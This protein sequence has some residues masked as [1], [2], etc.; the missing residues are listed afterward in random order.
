MRLK[1]HKK[2]KPL[3]S[4]VCIDSRSDKHLDWVSTT[5]KSIQAQDI[6][7]E[8]IVVPNIGRKQTIGKCWNAGIKEAK[9]DWIVFVGDDDYVAFDYARVLNNWIRDTENRGANVV[10]VATYMTFFEDS[11]KR[12]FKAQ[13]STGA[14]KRDYLLEYPFNEKLESGVDREYIEEALKRGSMSTI[15]EYYFGYYYRKHEDYSCAGEVTFIEEPRDYYFCTS[16]RIF[17]DSITKRF[18]R[19]VGEENI[20]ISPHAE[21]ELIHRSKIIWVEWANEK[22][23]VIQNADIDAYKILRLHAYEAF[24][25]SIKSLDFRKWDLVILIDHYIKDYIERQY[26]KIKNA[27]VIPNGIELDRYTINPNKQK[28]NKI[29]YA[30]YLSRKKGIGELILLAESFPEYEFHCA[31][32]YQEDDIA[33]YFKYKKPKNVFIHEWKYDKAMNEFYQD[34]SFILNTSLRESQAMT[35]MEGMACGLSPLI[36]GWLGAEEVY[37]KEWIYNSIEDFRRLLENP[38]EPSE[39]R[40]FI[41]NRYNIENIYPILENILLRKDNKILDHKK[42]KVA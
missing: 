37:K 13:Q 16:N 36:R 3:L 14:W 28:N 33:D 10:N 23:V 9:C 17:L 34:K 26:G 22:A 15:I 1:L 2:E 12:T 21:S 5:I 38:I 39:C 41:K 6:P 25:D 8:L 27:V 4:F 40:E 24:H 42:V 35:I 29:A 19:T 18:K 32:R 20:M 7:I 31:G 11:G 30:G